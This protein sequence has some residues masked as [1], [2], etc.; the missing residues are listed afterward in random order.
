[1]TLRISVLGGG[2]W[3]TTFAAVVSRNA[4]VLLWARDAGVVEEINERHA[5]SRYLPG[6]ALPARVRATVDIDD[7]ITQADVLVVAVPSHGVRA[8]LERVRGHLH[9]WIPVISLT[10]GLE[11]HTQ[12]RMSEI[13]Q[14]VLPGHP[15]GVLT[16]PNLAPEILR[17]QA[18]ASVLAMEDASILEE[19][20]SVFSTG[21]YRVYSNNDTVGCELGGVLK[22]IIAIACGIGD[23]MGAGD[24]TR[25]A[26]ITRGLAEITRIG[27]ALGGRAETF[28]GLAGIGDLVT[29][30]TSP[31]SRNRHVG[32]QLGRGRKLEEIV[33][34]MRMVAEGVKSTPVMVE[35]AAAHGIEIPMIAEINRVLNGASARQALRTLMRTNAGAEAAPG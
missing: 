35:L 32:E 7:C 25:S 6:L 20:R 31:L 15:P 10:K 22:N 4:P 14:Q 24:N 11:A 18:A 34:E 12:L 29:T 19:L 28:S 13:V 17:G 5:N 23:G 2:S 16:G 8:V 21:L 3:G 30:C 33:S 26:L 9:P 27:V 1:M